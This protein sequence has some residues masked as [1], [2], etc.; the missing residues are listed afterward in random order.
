VPSPLGHLL[1]G[2]AAGWA[3][4]GPSRA[5]SSAMAAGGDAAITAGRSLAR[6][7]NWRRAVLFAALGT[8]ADV[9]LLI[10]R[11]SQF[12]HSVGM[13]LLVGLAAY[14]LL[15]A[16]RGRHV[17]PRS[18][19]LV[20]LAAAAAYGSHVLLDWLGQDATPPIGI[21]ALWPFNSAYYLSHADIFWGISREPWRPG[22]AWHDAVAIA[23]EFV[24]MGTVAWG[25]WWFRRPRRGRQVLPS[26]P[27]DDRQGLQ[28]SVR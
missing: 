18:A 24:L 27:A 3:V 6:R 9:D 28:S 4:T 22:A 7:A 23:R 26:P 19:A 10:G 8:A 21:T 17:A 12:T 15:R 13:A 20:G 11:H 16:R 25:V 14:A 5:P 1:G 2:F